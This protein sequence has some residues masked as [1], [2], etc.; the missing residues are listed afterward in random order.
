MKIYIRS[1]TNLPNKLT[2]DDFMSYM[3]S[4]D[5][6]YYNEVTSDILES[7]LS[8]ALRDLNL[9]SFNLPSGYRI[10]DLSIKT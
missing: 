6:R 8:S 2:L 4:S 9:D 3:T 10:R 7:G 1:A 5:L